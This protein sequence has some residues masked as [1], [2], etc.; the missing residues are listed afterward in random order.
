MSEDP[1]K[2]AG[3]GAD[4]NAVLPAI[5]GAKVN[6]RT[7]LEF[8]GAA[9]AP[10]K[11]SAEA[12]RVLASTGR[13]SAEEILS[14]LPEDQV[15]AV[16]RS[17]F[18]SSEILS[19]VKVSKD[20]KGPLAGKI[21]SYQRGLD[22][23]HL[24]ESLSEFRGPGVQDVL[25]RLI[26]AEGAQKALLEKVRQAHLSEMTEGY[27]PAQSDPFFLEQAQS[28]ESEF[29]ETLGFLQRQPGDSP[30]QGVLQ[31]IDG[32]R[33]QLRNSIAEEMGRL[34]AEQVSE[35]LRECVAQYDVPFDP[36]LREA[37][38]RVVPDF[39]ALK[40]RIG[41]ECRTETVRRRQEF[42]DSIRIER[43]RG[44]IGTFVID[45][46]RI[47]PAQR[48][49]VHMKIGTLFPHPEDFLDARKTQ[50]TPVGD[51]LWVTTSSLIVRAKLR[52]LE[53][54]RAEPGASR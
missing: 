2:D 21:L 7:F 6:R 34:S 47:D 29:K 18:K 17:L 28:M 27:V 45:C 41:D 49:F 24:K 9:S 13:L 50:T 54:G 8:L 11:L 38:Q 12:S 37:I 39:D 42:Q 35:T 44:A 4:L 36:E 14:F 53:S 20:F 22:D 30:V 16:A 43:V 3:E 5:A 40:T 26:R 33:S 1:N 32:Q 52:E 15:V 51:K 25:K 48:P 23:A 19:C 10:V 46:S 31:F